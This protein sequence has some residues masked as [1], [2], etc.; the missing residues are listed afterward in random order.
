MLSSYALI[1]RIAVNMKKNHSKI[2]V[3]FTN[4]LR[5]Y[6]AQLEHDQKHPQYVAGY[7]IYLK[8]KS[9]LLKPLPIKVGI[10]TVKNV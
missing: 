3:F 6:F 2:Y 1:N 5:R 9:E 7:V 10:K 8:Y 4:F